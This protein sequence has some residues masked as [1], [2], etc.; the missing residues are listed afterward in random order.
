MSQELIYTSAPRGIAPSSSG[1]CTVAHDAAMPRLLIMKLERLSAYDF[2][3]DLTDSRSRMNPENYVHTRLTGGEQVSV[4]SRVAFCG[5][6]YSGR[7]NKIAHHFSVPG[8]EQVRG[9]PG[10]MLARMAEKKLFREE[11]AGQANAALPARDLR[12][13]LPDTP[14]PPRPANAWAR[15]GDAGW[16]GMLAQA[17]HDGQDNRKMPSYVLYNPGQEILPLFEESLAVLPESERWQV[18]FATYYSTMLPP[19]CHYHWRGV[20]AGSLAAKE[21]R[22]FPNALV[23]DLTKPLPKAENNRYTVAARDGHVLELLPPRTAGQVHRRVHSGWRPAT[24]DE[25]RIQESD[26]VLPAAGRRPPGDG[27]RSQQHAADGRSQ[28]WVKHVLGAAIIVLLVANGFTLL[29]LVK[30]RD[31]AGLLGGTVKQLEAQLK[32]EREKA[33]ELEKNGLRDD[34]PPAPSVKAGDPKP[35][36]AGKP[37]P[38]AGDSV[39]PGQKPG[40]AGTSASPGGTAGAEAGGFQKE[41]IPREKLADATW[42]STVQTLS[43]MSGTD[44]NGRKTMK[45]ELNGDEYRIVDLP[46]ELRQIVKWQSDGEKA[47]LKTAA[48][49]AY[50]LLDCRFTREQGKSFLVCARIDHGGRLKEFQP[51]LDQMVVELAAGYG[52]GKCRVYQCRAKGAENWIVSKEKDARDFTVPWQAI[53]AKGGMAGDAQLIEL[54]GPGKSWTKTITGAKLLASLEPRPGGTVHVEVQNGAFGYFRDS[55]AE[56]TK[57]IDAADAE[58]RRT[59]SRVQSLKTRNGKPDAAQIERGTTDVTRK[60]K[61]RDAL[62]GKLDDVKARM[63]EG[64]SLIDRMEPIQLLDPWGLPFAT[65]SVSFDPSVIR[66]DR[67]GL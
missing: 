28:D 41:I 13:L 12:T 20:L 5:A 44:K 62:L 58:I 29:A 11:W 32:Q 33:D 64:A 59:E 25:I 39:K 57:T 23:I 60:K 18:C 36:P 4:L 49:F 8:G 30:A 37:A 7:T 48:G 31:D 27:Y 46:P 9:G 19:D 50:D 43:G 10:W 55:A 51:V 53:S 45:F 6:D 52:T 54:N 40:Q 67:R 47:L 26:D 42:L 24:E 65:I 21:I 66:A 3:F 2:H 17:A 34:G 56:A 1:F 14:A 22:R 38:K 35:Q 61:E 15:H 63:Y 16:A